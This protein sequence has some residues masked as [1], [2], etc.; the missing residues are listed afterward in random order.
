[1]SVPFVVKDN[2][3]IRTEMK[4]V[5]NAMALG[6]IYEGGK[7]KA[8]LDG[9]ADKLA[10]LYVSTYEGM[11]NVSPSTAEMIWLDL[12]ANS[13]AVV[14]FLAEPDDS[15]RGRIIMNMGLQRMC[16]E[17][18]IVIRLKLHPRVKNVTFIDYIYGAGS[19]AAFI[20]P[21]DNTA[22]DSGLIAELTQLAKSASAGGAKVVVMAAVE[23]LF[24][25]TASVRGQNVSS[26]A[27]ENAI[28]DYISSLGLAG[29][30]YIDEARAAAVKAGA[31]GIDF[32]ELWIDDQRILPRD[33]PVSWDEK[34]VVDRTV[35]QP[36]VIAA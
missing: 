4:A 13:V 30:F 20:E 34:I 8:I 27:I 6:A 2:M 18:A 1:M 23:R 11:L 9:V 12:I 24:R 25:M 5:L 10:D 35:P 21:L 31:K 16:N 29:G 15:L 7:A 19:Y 33:F 22:A 36:I 32:H 14:R 28:R 3:T 17:E 26:S